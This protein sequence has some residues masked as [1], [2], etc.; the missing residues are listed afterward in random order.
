[1]AIWL[2]GD[3]PNAFYSCVDLQV[4]GGQ[5]STSTTSPPAGTTTTVAPRAKAW[6]AGAT[7]A[8]GDTVTYNGKT[9][10]CLQAHTAYDPTWTPA[11]TPALWKET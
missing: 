4:G 10:R 2:I 1:M 5:P 3:T 9:Y 11:A 6:A 8:V 7:Y